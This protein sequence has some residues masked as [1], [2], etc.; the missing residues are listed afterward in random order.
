MEEAVGGEVAQA[1]LA[2][3]GENFRAAAGAFDDQSG[4]GDIPDINPVFEIA[5]GLPG[6]DPAKIEGGGPADAG[7]LDGAGEGAKDLERGETGV[8]I[9]IQSG[10]DQGRGEGGDGGDGEGAPVAFG[11][12]IPGGG[13]TLIEGGGIDDPGADAAGGADGD[14]AAPEGQA[15]REIDGAV[16][17]IDDP[18]AAA[19]VGPGIGAG[20]FLAEDAVIGKAPAQDRF[21]DRLG[22]QVEPELDIMG[23]GGDDLGP[24]AA[25][26]PGVLA[27][28]VG[29]FAGGVEQ[30]GG[31]GE[32]GV[33][34]PRF[35]GGCGPGGGA[36][37]GGGGSIGGGGGGGGGIGQVDLALVWSFGFDS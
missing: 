33:G 18:L 15:M 36:G 3:V 16:D 6:G 13:V 27:G 19:V 34:W 5:V 30:F 37:W 4:G 14:G 2:E 11:G 28:G 21:G 12:A 9:L 7:F 26:L 1:A 8:D 31:G 20:G 32:G 22:F 17:R 29:G 24:P 35:G 23:I 25:V 10:H